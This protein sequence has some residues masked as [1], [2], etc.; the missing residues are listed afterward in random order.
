VCHAVHTVDYRSSRDIDIQ[1][2]LWTALSCLFVVCFYG[3]AADRKEGGTTRTLDLNS[4][5]WSVF[6]N[7]TMLHEAVHDTAA[8]VWLSHSLLVYLCSDAA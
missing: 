8:I 4:N 3:S 1:R 7:E 5:I 6:R 2:E